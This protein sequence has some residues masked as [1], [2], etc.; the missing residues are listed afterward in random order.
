MANIQGI[1][2]CIFTRPYAEDDALLNQYVEE[3]LH[4]ASWDLFHQQ[5]Q[6]CHNIKE[7]NP[8]KLKDGALDLIFNACRRQFDFVVSYMVLRMLI[9]YRAGNVD[10]DAES[11]W[12]LKDSLGEEGWKEFQKAVNRYIYNDYV[13]SLGEKKAHDYFKR[14]G[15]LDQMLE[16]RSN[17]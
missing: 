1:Y 15:R 3:A 7:K 5:E 13:S 17:D 4:R 8:P 16:F 9:E 12:Y 2:D 14:I 11:E 10:L 6:L